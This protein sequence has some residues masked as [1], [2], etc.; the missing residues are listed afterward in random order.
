MTLDASFNRKLFLGH[1]ASLGSKLYVVG[2]ASLNSKLF[3]GSDVS[4]GSKLYV[5]GDV[6]LNS[7]M[8]VGQD[9]SLGSKLCIMGNVGIGAGTNTAEYRLDV[10]GNMRIFESVGTRAT[11][12]EGSLILEHSDASGVSS[13]MFKSKNAAN[14]FAYIQYEENGGLGLQAN[15]SEKG[16]FTIGTENDPTTT[17]INDT[18]SLFPGAGSGFVGVNTKLPL[19]NFDVSGGMRVSGD[20]S[21]NSRVYTRFLGQSYGTVIGASTTIAFPLNRF[22]FIS[23]ATAITIT[24]PTIPVGP[25]VYEVTFRRATAS[26][27][28]TFNSTTGQ[29][30]F[31]G[32]YQNAIT[33]SVTGSGT[34]SVV[35]GRSGSNPFATTF[36]FI[37][38]NDGTNV[39]WFEI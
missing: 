28:T 7:R 20:A 16:V 30:I 11:A 4:L 17:T 23:V 9:V 15:G 21:L 8:F 18:I 27:A 37:A 26:A 12:T 34:T 24:L 3:V 19:R 31:T 29:N 32:Y 38:Y 14:D 5:V 25:E 6:S 13:I 2:D 1:D 36:T 33:G 39:G 35:Y 22:Y 10:C